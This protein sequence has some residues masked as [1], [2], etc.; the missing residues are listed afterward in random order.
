MGHMQP[1]DDRN[2]WYEGKGLWSS[3]PDTEWNDW[4]W[5]M[6]NRITKQSDLDGLLS[7][8]SNEVAGFSAAKDRLSVGITPYFLNL[9]DPNDP[10]CPIRRASNS[11]H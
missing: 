9:L 1:T 7:L 2:S 3:I 10:L 6:R 4:K 5:Q 8:A 11:Q